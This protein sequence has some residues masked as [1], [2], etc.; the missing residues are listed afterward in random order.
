MNLLFN[1]GAVDFSAMAGRR[2][3]RWG[4]RRERAG[5][6]SIL[7]D[8][9]DVSFNMERRDVKAGQRLADRQ[10]ISFAELMRRALKAHLKRER[11]R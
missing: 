7:E 2:K 8:P 5:R 11:R 6:P 4:G 10:G 9:A 3:A 1:T